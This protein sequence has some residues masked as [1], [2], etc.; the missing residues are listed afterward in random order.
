MAET[1]DLGPG[2]LISY[3]ARVEARHIEHYRGVDPAAWLTALFRSV[4]QAAITAEG[5]QYLVPRVTDRI[6]VPDGGEDASLTVQLPS[7]EPRTAGIVNPGH[8]IYQFKWRSKR[9]NVFKSA[10]GELKKLK[11]SSTLPDYYVF[12]TNVDLTIPEHDKIKEKL[13]QGC[14]EFPAD[15]IVVIGASEL[16]D[17]VNN[18]PRIRV[19]HFDVALGL[20]TLETAK[21]AAERRYGNRETSP[22]LFDREQEILSLK[23]FLDDPDA[24]VM[25]I[26][27]PQGAGKTRVVAESLSTMHEKAVWAREIPL[28]ITGLIQVLDESFHPA[29]LVIDDADTHPAE[30]LRKAL[31]AARLK[32]II[33]CPWTTGAPGTTSLAIKPFTDSDAD[34]FLNQVF[35]ELPYTHRGW[36]SDNFGG[37][38]GLLLQAATALRSGG[39]PDPL[40]EPQYE[41][42]LQ[43]YEERMLK[44]LGSIGD[45]LESLSILPIFRV[46]A[47]ADADLRLLC[48][49]LQIDLAKVLKNIALLKA[50]DLIQPVGFRDDGHFQVT[51]PLL[52]RRIAQ[53]AIVGISNRLAPLYEQ[54][55]P[56]GRA[57]LIR[58]V[59][60]LQDEPSVRGFLSRLFSSSGLFRDLQSVTAN[61]ASVRALAETLPTPT[62]R[63]L[64][65]VL[66]ATT[67]TERKAAL[68]EAG[69]WPVG[70]KRWE[71]VSALIALVQR[72]ET[73]NDGANGLLALAEVEQAEKVGRNGNA[74]RIFTEIFN[75]RHPHIAKDA[76]IRARLLLRLAGA[77]SPEKRCVV[78]MAA[79]HCLKTEYSL[80]AWRGEG[81]TP[82]EPG[83]RATL[84]GEVHEAVRPAVE[85]LKR[86]AIDLDPGVRG[87]AISGLY[88]VGGIAALGLAEEA[89]TALEFLASCSLDGSQRARLVEGVAYLLATLKKILGGAE[90]AEWRIKLRSCIERGEQ[91]FTQLTSSNFRSRF[92]HWLGPTPMRAHVRKGE[93][94][95]Y[96]EIS[97]QGR[98]LAEEVIAT[99]SLFGADLLDWVAE[100]HAQNG[101]YF[102]RALG[103]LDQGQMWLKPLE[104][105]INR[106]NGISSLGLYVAGWSLAAPTDA[107]QYLDRIA[108][109]GTQWSEIAIN[110]TWRIGGSPQGVQRILRCVREGGANRAAVARL[111]TWGLWRKDL[112]VK[113]FLDLITGLRD[114]TS[115]VD[116]ALLELLHGFWLE[117][118]S[119]QDS[120]GPVAREILLNTAEE[121][122]RSYNTHDWDSL[123]AAL[124]EWNVDVGFKL[125][126]AHLQ[127]DE[128]SSGI[129]F[130]H[131]RNQLIE[132]LSTKDRA[133][134]VRELLERSLSGSHRWSVIMELPNLLQLETDCTVILQFAQE[135]GP[136][137]ARLVAR[138]LDASQSDFWKFLPDFLDQWGL[139]EEVVSGIRQSIAGIRDVY[140][141]KAEILKPRLEVLKKLQTHQNPLVQDMAYQAVNELLKEMKESA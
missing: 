35:P 54:L 39:S 3:G 29:V 138:N 133:R 60:E 31:E 20:C 62:A 33:I 45:V 22:P 67:I 46:S 69:E 102:L 72:R 65:K 127:G 134:L 86:L 73:F 125:L 82:P 7:G 92:Q 58:R 101:G 24:R 110:A 64:R 10:T 85:V 21:E 112:S 94:A 74:T 141:D 129:F 14:E 118:E 37:C 49:V 83:W 52:A 70:R 108:G 123:A 34:K 128:E 96:S 139:D 41:V 116:W 99:P 68:R 50:R 84:W 78:A 140:S 80:H 16:K 113:D 48:D 44:G 98:K 17:R 12:V 122:S 87:E 28:Q 23:H 136:E 57:G 1:G 6:R 95:D 9:E 106:L 131:H 56:E 77:D 132:A 90:D 93:H 124:V 114:G 19:A 26:I 2:G 5:L 121:A 38:P 119:E 81:I 107:E 55:S 18:D 135:R 61:A 11:D 63:E 137:A 100:E 66:E 40:Q 25:V 53:R 59:A 115:E 105:R 47:D 15:R 89:T 36:L 91:L 71:V 109:K 8:T 27:G 51:P 13:R 88:D 75:W 4:L 32:T 117:Q 30:V 97:Q 43:A 120:L 130:F 42:I 79:A 126:F 111:L 104:E 103:E 76:R